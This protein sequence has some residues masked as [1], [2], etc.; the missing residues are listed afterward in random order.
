MA[1]DLLSGE[2]DELTLEIH[3]K[4]T[5]EVVIR[6]FNYF[7]KATDGTTPLYTHIVFT[8][9][10]KEDV[11]KRQ[12]LVVVA[13]IAILVAVSIPIFTGKL[14]EARENTDKANVR[15]A[16]AAMVTEFLQA[17]EQTASTMW[18]DAD[19]G[20][21]VAQNT[22]TAGYNKAKQNNIDADGAC[23]LYTS[24]LRIADLVHIRN[25]FSA[26]R[27][28]KLSLTGMRKRE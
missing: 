19:N 28:V 27:A 5:L 17:K 22:L 23:L 2:T 9:E 21:M 14:N 8:V 4:D 13:I 16:K 12:L 26:T 1:G 11:Y 15:A 24:C 20:K 18:Y 7:K 3:N 25:R 10:G 6:D